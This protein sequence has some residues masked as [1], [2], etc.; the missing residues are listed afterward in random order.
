MV[1][2]EPLC[3]CFKIILHQKVIQ[4]LVQPHFDANLRVSNAR[5]ILIMVLYLILSLLQD[6]TSKQSQT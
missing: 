6:L 2:L 4:I 1:H 5:P 3:S